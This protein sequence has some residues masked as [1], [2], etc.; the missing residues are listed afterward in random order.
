MPPKLSINSFHLDSVH[1]NLLPLAVSGYNAKRQVG[2]SVVCTGRRGTPQQKG[3]NPASVYT[4]SLAWYF[5]LKVTSDLLFWLRLQKCQQV[6][7][8]PSFPLTVF[9]D[10]REKDRA[11][12]EAK[13]CRFLKR[14]VTAIMR[15]LSHGV[16]R[17]R[18]DELEIVLKRKTTNKEK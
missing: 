4:F 1:V 2:V 13:K 12:L 8:I 6:P 15:I 3:W 11:V 5:F 10:F 18:R 7:E 17:K 14:K 16:R 9:S